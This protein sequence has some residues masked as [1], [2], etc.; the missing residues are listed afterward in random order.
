[1]KDEMA[2]IVD[3]F[4]LDKEDV[5]DF[6]TKNNNRADYFLNSAWQIKPFFEEDAKDKSGK[7]LVDK[8]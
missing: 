3:R 2:N 7:L 6:E 5:E 1:M 8:S 4:D